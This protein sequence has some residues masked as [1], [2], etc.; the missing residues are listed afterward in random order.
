MRPFEE[1]FEAETNRIYGLILK[2]IGN[3]SEAEDLAQQVFL[4]AYE[5]YA[6]FREESAVSTWLYR[7][8]MNLCVDHIRSKKSRR[9]VEERGPESG[10]DEGLPSA[11]ER[12]ADRGP[13]PAERAEAV[14]ISEKVGQ[15]L[16]RLD[17]KYREVLILREFENLSYEEIAAMLNISEKL[18][19]V[20]LIRARQ[21]LAEL[22]KDFM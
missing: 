8:A 3:P 5:K 18:V 16:S 19:S 14:E 20:R 15:A 21:K 4:K 12:A 13:T 6:A 22:L 17:E 1:V 9:S 7:I 10:E 11:V 2:M